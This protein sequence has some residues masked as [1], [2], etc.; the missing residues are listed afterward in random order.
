MGGASALENYSR[1]P[2]TR[3]SRYRIL[4]AM[5]V[6]AA[7]ACDAW[8]PPRRQ[9]VNIDPFNQIPNVQ[10]GIRAR[11]LMHRRLQWKPAPYNGYTEW[12]G[13]YKMLYTVN[14]NLYSEQNRPSRNARIIS[15]SASHRVTPEMNAEQ[16]WIS[17][18]PEISKTVPGKPICV[19]FTEP[20]R[21]MMAFWRSPQ[22]LIS[23][24]AFK[25]HLKAD[26]T[27]DSQ[28]PGNFFVMQSLSTR[29]TAIIS[30]ARLHMNPKGV[31]AHVVSCDSAF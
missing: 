25:P 23:L 31:K 26:G 2:M 15:I 10:L 12:I 9:L 28:R 1:R 18:F 24:S 6:L 5:I 4:G 3:S 22:G 8:P 20:E 27:A 13:N 16:E 19:R 30:R 29:L 17:K 21:G 14:E 7:L 11:E